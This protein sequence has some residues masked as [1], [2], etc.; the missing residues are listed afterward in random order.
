VRTDLSN[1]LDP[2]EVALVAS[3]VGCRIERAEWFDA[4]PTQDWAGHEKARLWLDDGRVVLFGAWGHDAWGVTV[5][6]ETVTDAD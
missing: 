2:E 6:L 3:L 4:S 1:D 5:H